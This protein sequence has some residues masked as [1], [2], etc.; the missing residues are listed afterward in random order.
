MRVIPEDNLAYPCLI[1]LDS[2]SSGSG[3]L[4]RADNQVYFVTA[5]HVLFDQ[6]DVIQGISAEITCPTR[7]IDDDTTTVF[8]VNLLKSSVIYSKNADVAAIFLYT[9]NL[10]DKTRVE[11]CD[12][13]DAKSLGKTG[14]VSV[15]ARNSTKLLKDVL[16]SNDII[17]YGYP[18]SLGI[19]GSPQFDYERPLLRKGIVAGVYKKQQ[20]IIIDSAVYYGNSGGPVVEI[21]MQGNS[22]IHKVIGVVSEFVPFVEQWV[23]TKNNLVN[24]ELSNSGYSVVVPMDRVFELIRFDIKSRPAP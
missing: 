23:N 19:Q 9:V 21:E 20:T 18:S 2:G 24:T 5:K 13:V 16:I 4:L 15:D 12:G 10:A 14:L 6:A 11:L 7:D 8:T 1:K 22:L 17:I 3:F